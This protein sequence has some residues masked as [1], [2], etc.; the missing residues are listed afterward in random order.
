M[1]YFFYCV[2]EI[3]FTIVCYLTNPIVVLFADEY[4]N[5]PYSLRYWQTWDNTLDVG[6]MVTEGKVP[7][8]FQYDYGKHYV[9]HWENHDAGIAGYVDI[10]DPSFS[11]WERIQRYFCRLAWLYRNTGYGFSYYVTGKDINGADIV[12]T[13]DISTDNYRFQVYYTKDAFMVRYD[14]AWCKWFRWRIF[15]GWKM[16]SVKTTET[17]RCMLALFISPFRRV[18]SGL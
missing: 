10:I 18:T 16:Q 14:K 6:W 11:L 5:L 12:K 1:M 15:L 13:E 4:G 8:L 9:Y 3:I 2:L 17:K 7:K